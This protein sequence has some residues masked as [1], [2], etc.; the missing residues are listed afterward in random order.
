MLMIYEAF[1][2][3]YLG[4]PKKKTKQK[5]CKIEPANYFWES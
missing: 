5:L 3:C 2:C 4:T 1:F